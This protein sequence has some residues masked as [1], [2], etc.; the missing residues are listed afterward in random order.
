MRP[1]LT[2]G[3][4][5]ALASIAIVV[6]PHRQLARST[7]PI[8]TPHSDGPMQQPSAWRPLLQNGKATGWRGYQSKEL[9]DG[10][11]VVDGA[12]TRVAQAGDIVFDEDFAN[13]ELELEWKVRE[14]GNSG[15]FYRATEKLERIYHSGPEMQVLDDAHHRDGGS[16]LTSAGAC[17]GLYPVPRGIVNP[18]G[19]WN[20]VRLVVNG[21]HVEHWLN[22]KKACEYELWSPEWEAKVKASKFA[23]WPEYGR[24]KTGKIGLQDHGDWVAFRNIR[25]RVLP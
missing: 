24:A 19:E 3:A 20:A 25:V 10:W 2:H 11:K 22:G 9:S 6:L 14:G 8:S 1:F 4:G 18:A 17:Y 13:F 15:I 7:E 21:A 12:L 23:E 16:E 5:V